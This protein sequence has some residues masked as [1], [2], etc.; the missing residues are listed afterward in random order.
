MKLTSCL[1]LLA[2]LSLCLASQVSISK[3]SN[4]N[5]DAKHV[6]VVLA[7][8][9]VKQN[10]L[11]SSLLSFG[12]AQIL[13]GA[14][15]SQQLFG[16]ADFKLGQIHEVSRWS[17][18]S[19]ALY[20]FAVRHNHATRSELYIESRFTV[21]YLLTGASSAKRSSITFSDYN[22]KFDEC[23]TLQGAYKDVSKSHHGDT[24]IQQLLGHGNGY[25]CGEA[26]H[27][28]QLTR[29]PASIASLDVLAINK[30]AVRSLDDIS[31]YRYDVVLGDADHKSYRVDATFIVML[32]KKFGKYSI[33]SVEYTI[34][35]LVDNKEC[36]QSDYKSDTD[37]SD[38]SSS[39]SDCEQSNDKKSSTKSRKSSSDDSD[40]SDNKHRSNSKNKDCSDDQSDKC[41]INSKSDCSDDQSDK[42]RTNY[43]NECSDDQSDKCRTSSKNND[44]SDDRSDKRRTNSKNDCSVDQSDKRK[45]NSKDDCSDDSSDKH[46]DK[47][48]TR[49]SNNNSNKSNN[50]TKRRA[51]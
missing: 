14:C 48:S 28:N 10:S 34:K 40:C 41:R 26:R 8:S 16:A 5:D 44:C 22:I 17:D 27:R 19:R 35:D 18:K 43:K 39:D 51:L 46:S 13:S 50:N 4:N 23:A 29:L 30:V 38:E 20:K 7:D 6:F 32:C 37:C 33:V 49:R 2:T 24:L 42:R 36:G 1:L 31:Y 25:V 45:I 11:V 47:Q 12:S 15:S 21:Q 9:E 3:S